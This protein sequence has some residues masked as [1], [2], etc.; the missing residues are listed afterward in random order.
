MYLTLNLIN[1]SFT[2]TK[3]ETLKD[4]SLTVEKGEFICIVGPS[5]CGK[6][7]LLN[8]VALPLPVFSLPRSK[9][10]LYHLDGAYQ[11]CLQAGGRRFP[12]DKR[13]AGTVY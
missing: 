1:K 8:L 9:L 12:H 10:R 3:K 13:T 11:K 2:N 4:I 7:T 5:G 6:S